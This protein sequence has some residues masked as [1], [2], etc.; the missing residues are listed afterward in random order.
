M[1]A[2][3]RL[4]QNRSNPVSSTQPSEDSTDSS[5]LA[6]APSIEDVQQDDGR[7]PT[8]SDA[9]AV[10][11]VAEAL[12]SSL[13]GKNR[14]PYPL[15]PWETCVAHWQDGQ[16]G[17]LQWVFAHAHLATI[18]ARLGGARA[19]DQQSVSLPDGNVL[20]RDDAERRL[21][22]KERTRVFLPLRRAVDESGLR[23]L[24][25][26]EEGSQAFSQRLAEA[27]VALTRELTD[28]ARAEASMGTLLECTRE[29]CEAAIQ[30][31]EEYSEGPIRS[32][33]EF[34]RA[35]DW[36][37][38]AG[39][40]SHEGARHYA[41]ALRDASAP[42]AQRALR[43][44]QA[45]RMGAGHLVSAASGP[46]RVWVASSRRARRTLDLLEG[47]SAALVCALVPEHALRAQ[48]EEAARCAGVAFS[49]GAL[50]PTL[51]RTILGESADLAERAAR[52]GRGAWLLRLRWHAVVARTWLR[53]AACAPAD[54]AACFPEVLAEEARAAFG[55]A[56]EPRSLETR[57]AALAPWPGGHALRSRAVEEGRAAWRG[58]W[59]CALYLRLRERFDEAFPMVARPY[60]ILADAGPA[61]QAGALDL[62]ALFELDAPEA[63]VATWYAELS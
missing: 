1:A 58:A 55:V 36:P 63:A 25:L 60:E 49:L 46:L 12:L 20:G 47:L 28:T 33:A 61:L 31:L 6:W 52:I 4:S 54:F 39:A 22:E 24:Q 41:L 3:A 50:S 53:S 18:D 34:I 40:F 7:N 23:G 44:V 16:P 27:D 32:W 21:A 15:I 9:V 5:I 35:W 42:R 10:K 19:W 48:G 29:S 37:D 17:A 14:E 56:P 8:T 45:P 2:D 43:R 26:W 38:P 13:A 62:A 57:L 11:A 59:G 30:M 51:R